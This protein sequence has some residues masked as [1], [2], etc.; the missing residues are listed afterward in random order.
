M[1]AEQRASKDTIG[2]TGTV[3]ASYGRGVLVQA[4]GTTLHCALSGRKQRVVCGDRVTWVYPPAADGPSVQSIEPRRNLIE[5]I[6]ARGRAEPVAANIDR[7][8]IVV[9]AEPAPD[10]FLVDRYWAGAVLKDLDGL[11]IVNKL[12][13]GTEPIR[14]ELETYR[15][16]HLNCIEV[17]SQSGLGLAEL[18]HSLAGSVT[19]LVGQSGVGKSSLVNALSPDAAAQTAELTRDVEGRHT[20]TTARWYQLEATSAIIDAPG[21]RDFA[22]PASLVRAAERGFIEIHQLSADCRFKDCRHMEEPGCA[23]RTAVVGQEI[24]PRRYESY[25]RLFRLYEKLAPL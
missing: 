1:V 13:L 2:A 9:A 21:V 15:N 11:L 22:P 7:L 10:W 12:D 8:A 5:R 4:N 20:T 17:S 24:A 3:L 19:L 14:R 23:V 25:R 18:G 6:D 16:L